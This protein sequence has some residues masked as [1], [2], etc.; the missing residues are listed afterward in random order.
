MGITKQTFE[1]LLT[2]QQQTHKKVLG[3]VIFFLIFYPLYRLTI[4][5]AE[6]FASAF[7]ILL[8]IVD[9]YFL[10]EYPKLF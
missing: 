7:L 3:V 1:D 10:E 2:R 9:D 6:V 5:K 4:K 8:S